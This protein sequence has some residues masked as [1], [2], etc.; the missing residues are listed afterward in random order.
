MLAITQLDTVELLTKATNSNKV[1]EI[2]Y[3]PGRRRIQPHVLGLS[4]DRNCLLRAYQIEGASE[5]GEHINWKLFRVD[6]I[7]AIEIT[8]ETFDADHPDYNPDDRVMKGGIIA[9]VRK[10]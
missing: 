1:V 2:V 3:R 5:S 7:E 9:R 8:D 6:K 4:K 10:V